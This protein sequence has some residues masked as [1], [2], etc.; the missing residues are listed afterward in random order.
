MLTIWVNWLYVFIQFLIQEAD[1]LKM[2]ARLTPG[3]VH[4]F[5]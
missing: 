3:S 5:H 4:Y 1:H 2:N